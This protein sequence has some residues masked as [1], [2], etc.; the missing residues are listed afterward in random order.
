MPSVGLTN[1]DLFG[2]SLSISGYLQRNNN[3]VSVEQACEHFDISKSQLRKLISTLFTLEN[4]NTTDFY[5][6]FDLDAFDKKGILK[7]NRQAL[8][9]QPPKLSNQQVSALAMGLEYLSNFEELANDPELLQLMKIFGASPRMQARDSDKGELLSI[10]RESITNQKQITCEYIN[11]KGERGERK[12]EPLRIDLVNGLYY[13]R[14]FCPK[15]L[16]VRSFRLDRMKNPSI[17]DADLTKKAKRAFLSEDINTATD[18]EKLVEVSVDLQAKDFFRSFS[19]KQAP[20]LVDGRLVGRIHTGD[21]FSL[22]RHVIARGG[23]VRVLAPKEAVEA[24][25][26]AAQKLSVSAPEDED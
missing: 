5:F 16:Q 15:N 17:T 21:Y 20:Q 7:L 6:D 24:V 19:S 1:Q 10:L 26:Q 14:A 13:L 25:A 3:N 2:I 4:L 23:R 8:I 18:E 22:A 12:L 11:T 9:S